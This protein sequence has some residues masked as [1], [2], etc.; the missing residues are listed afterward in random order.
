MA[1]PRNSPRRTPY[2]ATTPPPAKRSL[3]GPLWAVGATVL[4]GYFVLRDVTADR[5]QR[6]TYGS[7]DACACAYSQ[8][9]CR[10]DN[11]RIVGPWYALDPSERRPDDPGAGRYCGSTR[12]G[13]TYLGAYDSRTGVEKGYRGGFGSTGGIR[14]ASS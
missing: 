10:Y 3:E 5:V 8:H 9:Q 14:S 4:I 7:M 1:R 2:R 6:N 13:G 11:G 12:G